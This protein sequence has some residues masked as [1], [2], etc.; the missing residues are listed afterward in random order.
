VPLL[1]LRYLVF[2]SYGLSVNAC[3]VISWYNTAMIVPPK[4]NTL[5][6]SFTA[7]IKDLRKY[8][9]KQ[10]KPQYTAD[11]FQWLRPKEVTDIKNPKQ[12]CEPYSLD[13]LNKQGKKYIDLKG[14]SPARKG[15]L[16]L[17]FA[18]KHPLTHQSF[19]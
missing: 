2:V 12:L 13:E 4:I 5:V 15:W 19:S 9:R 18:Q 7:L 8:H 6:K 17:T 3:H 14:E 10:G 16:M 11:R 1:V